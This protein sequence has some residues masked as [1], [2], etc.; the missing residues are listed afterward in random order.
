MRIDHQ[1]NAQRIREALAHAGHVAGAAQ[2]VGLDPSQVYRLLKRYGIQFQCQRQRWRTQP[3]LPEGIPTWREAKARYIRETLAAAGN[4]ASLA[5]RIA[6]IRRSS[7]YRLLRR[8][9]IPL[10][11][12]VAVRS[13]YANRG[14]AA[15]QALRT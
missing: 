9:G 12:P 3:V 8:Y 5:A 15:W 2:L 6:G 1:A 11:K 7:F 4:S 13:H 10:T 14:N